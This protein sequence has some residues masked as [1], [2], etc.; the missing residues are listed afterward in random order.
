MI[1]KLKG[2][3]FVKKLFSPK[4]T[5]LNTLQTFQIQLINLTPP[6][7]RQQNFYFTDL[8][9]IINTPQFLTLK[10]PKNSKKQFKKNVFFRNSNF[11]KNKY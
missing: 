4:N 5:Y 7:K 8:G 9:F 1:R 2:I 11:L 10:F 6:R 3:I